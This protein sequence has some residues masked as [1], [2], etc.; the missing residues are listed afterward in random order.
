ME[1]FHLLTLCL[2]VN[3]ISCF[4]SWWVY[5]SLSVTTVEIFHLITVC[6]NVSIYINAVSLNFISYIARVFTLNSVSVAS[7]LYIKYYFDPVMGS[8]FAV[9]IPN[10]ILIAFKHS[11]WKNLL[12]HS[13]GSFHY[14]F[15]L[16]LTRCL[17]CTMYFMYCGNWLHFTNY[18]LQTTF[19]KLHF[20]NYI[21]QTTFYT[22]M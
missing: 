20:T 11:L 13:N 21:L 19:Y 14:V 4:S 7:T 9:I 12:L 17:Q 22:G 6:W 16:K 2:N 15:V 8:H 18:I 5:V 1:I 10:L 3:I